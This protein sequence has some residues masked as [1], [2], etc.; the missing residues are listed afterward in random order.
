MLDYAANGSKY[1]PPDTLKAEFEARCAV[2]GIE[3]KSLLAEHLASGDARAFWANVGESITT[4]RLR[5]GVP[6]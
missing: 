3:A 6:G 2:D 5:S 1:W 4:G